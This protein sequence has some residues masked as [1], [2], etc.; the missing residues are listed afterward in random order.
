MNKTT[1]LLLTALAAVVILGLQDDR[2]RTVRAESNSRGISTQA[3]GSFRGLEGAW[4]ISITL[5]DGSPTPFRILRTV[6][7]TGIVD[8]YAFPPFTFTPGAV[9][10]SG[11]GDWQRTSNTIFNATV[12]YFQLKYLAAPGFGQVIDTIGTVRETIKISDDGN[13]YVSEFTTTISLPN[14][15]VVGTNPGKTVA[16]RIVPEAPIK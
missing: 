7:P 4:D 6:T 1:G 11:H 12:R 3:R 15:T 10:S 8:S 16:K 5:P 14:G 9:N 2:L 13:S